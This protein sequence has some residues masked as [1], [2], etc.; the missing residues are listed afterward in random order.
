MNRKGSP[1]SCRC[2]PV[3]SR[4][5]LRGVMLLIALFFVTAPA[6]AAAGTLQVVP[7][8]TSQSVARTALELQPAS[9]TAPC[10]CLTPEEAVERWG[11]SAS[12]CSTAACSYLTDA[13]GER[14][15][16]YCFKENPLVPASSGTAGS[17]VTCTATVQ[18]PVTEDILPIVTGTVPVLQVMTTAVPAG[19]EKL[20]LPDNPGPPVTGGTGDGGTGFSTGTFHT[21]TGLNGNDTVESPDNGTSGNYSPDSEANLAPLKINTGKVEFKSPLADWIDAVFSILFGGR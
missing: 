17:F 13:S 16:R 8:T 19:P 10:E 1:V 7:V 20:N 21:I 18:E 15:A 11:S 3:C 14:T 6:A 5:P 9:C 12:Q 4:T 2:L